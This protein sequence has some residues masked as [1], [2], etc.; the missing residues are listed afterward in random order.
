MKKQ[1]IDDAKD[2]VGKEAAEGKDLQEA[3]AKG[4]VSEVFHI[5]V[6]SGTLICLQQEEVEGTDGFEKI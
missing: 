2:D 3:D 6:H 4:D 1:R 5:G